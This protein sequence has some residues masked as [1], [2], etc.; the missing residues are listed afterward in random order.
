MA[1]QKK[2]CCQ[3]DKC[4]CCSLRLAAAINTAIMIV[5]NTSLL[6]MSSDCQDLD[7]HEHSATGNHKIIAG[8]IR[9]FHKNDKKGRKKKTQ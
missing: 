1:P 2:L 4:C 7:S 6:I 9:E 3:R 5:V 8:V